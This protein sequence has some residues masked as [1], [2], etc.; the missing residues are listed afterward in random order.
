MSVITQARKALKMSRPQFVEW[1][2]DRGVKSIP[3][4]IWEWETGVKSPRMNVRVVCR[5]ISAANAAEQIKA[6]DVNATDYN[7]QVTRIIIESQE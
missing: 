6:I 2:K 4:R 7:K 1:L 5:E 3:Q